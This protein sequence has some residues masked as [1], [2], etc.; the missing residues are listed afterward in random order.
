VE[1]GRKT[2]EDVENRLS[3]GQRLKEVEKEEIKSLENQIEKRRK[4]MESTSFRAHRRTWQRWLRS[5]F[6]EPS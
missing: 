4:M 5:E 2:K 3:E 1:Q 6:R